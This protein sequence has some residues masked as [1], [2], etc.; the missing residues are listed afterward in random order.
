MNKA[1]VVEWF[2]K[3]AWVPLSIDWTRDQARATKKMFA[4]PTAYEL[5][6]VTE[7]GKIRIRRW[8]REESK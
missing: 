2:D 3:R 8:V 1:W 4:S 5:R 6:R 7:N